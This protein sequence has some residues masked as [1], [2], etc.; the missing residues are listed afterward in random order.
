MCNWKVTRDTP[1]EA[2]KTVYISQINDVDPTRTEWQNA[3]ISWAKNWWLISWDFVS[4]YTDEVC[5]R[6]WDSSAAF[7]INANLVWSDILK[8]WT[9][10]VSVK[11][12]S[13]TPIIRADI[14]V[15]TTKV[16]SET[17]DKQ[18]SWDLKIDFEIDNT[19]VGASSLKIVLVD[20]NYYSW[21]KSIIFDSMWASDTNT[22][23]TNQDTNN[24]TSASLP[25][26]NIKNPS[27]WSIKIFEDQSFNLRFETSDSAWISSINI[28]LDWK[29]L[30][31]NLEAGTNVVP[32]NINNDIPVWN[33]TITVEAVNN[34]FSKSSKDINCE[35]LSR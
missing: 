28:Y 12:S 26:I 13:N 1:P 4:N 19:S 34:N 18:K 8:I 5:E 11:Y 20:E 16:K 7:D 25:S 10:T 3:A 35:I 27:S 32:I 30:N 15:W 33:H 17:I 2:V 9:N 14:Y 6:N 23:T 21:N 24:N 29:A 31:M 22:T